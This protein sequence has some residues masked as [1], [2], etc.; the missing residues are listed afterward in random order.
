MPRKAEQDG[1]DDR[2]PVGENAHALVTSSIRGVPVLRAVFRTCPGSLD[3]SW[4]PEAP[5]SS[6][7]TSPTRSSPTATTCSSIDDLSTGRGEN[8]PAAPRFERID[9]VDAQQLGEAIERSTPTSSATSRRR[10]A[11]PSRHERPE[12]DLDVNVR[13]TFNVCEAARAHGR[14]R[15]LRID[16]RRALRGQ[17]A[18]ADA[19][20]CAPEPLAPYGASKLA[21]EA[22]VAT[23]GDSTG[24]RTSSCRLGNVYGPRQQPHGEAGVVAIFSRPPAPRRARRSSTATASR[25]ATTC[26]SP[27]SRA[28][29][30]ARPGGRRDVQRRHGARR[31]ASRAARGPPARRRAQ[32]SSR[33]C[34]PLRPGELSEAHSTRG[35]RRELG[36]RA[37]DPRSSEGIAETF[38][39]F[40]PEQ[41]RRGR[42]A[43][44]RGSRRGSCRGRRAPS[45]VGRC[46]ARGRLSAAS[47]TR[48]PRRSP[49]RRARS[50]PSR[51]AFGGLHREPLRLLL[52]VVQLAERVAELHPAD[53]VLEALDDRRVVVGRARER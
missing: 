36:W 5:G 51:G 42:E 13:G 26:T 49:R 33:S 10:R 29:S 16:G 43:P 23:W 50:P 22:Y 48:A 4:S 15:R 8:V 1:D 2:L 7:R 44:E 52:R 21:G 28:R 40:A 20:D 27:T 39:A 14:A 24:S 35:D 17:R 6:A 25:R 9:I 3:V 11:S 41:L 37:D 19:G 46:R 12:H 31:R 53:E 30:S 32:R 34:E 47:R 45:S 38:R 18:A